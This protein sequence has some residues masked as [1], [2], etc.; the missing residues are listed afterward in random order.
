MSD[1]D[2]REFLKKSL[3]ASTGAAMAFSLEEQVLVAHAD[4]NAKPKPA[5]KPA[6]DFPKGKIGDVE[7]SRII[8]GGNLISGYAHSRDLVY[9]STL[10][11]HYFTDEKIFETLQLCE[12]QG[13]NAAMLKMDADTIRIVNTY[14]RERGGA[15][16]WIAQITNP[17]EMIPDA[18]KA[19]DMGA[20]GVFTT[21]QMGDELVRSNKVD[22]IAKTVEYVK[23]NGAIAGVSCHEI[24]VVEACEKGGVNADFY[25]KTFHHKHYWS[26]GIETRNDNLFEETP[27]KTIEVMKTVTKPW[28]AFKVLAAGAIPVQEGFEFAVKNGADFLCVGMFDFQVEE[29]ALVGKKVFAEFKERSRPWRG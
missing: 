16:Q 18:K 19:I 22:R 15:I 27:E 21:G 29:D 17:D 3:V 7:I 11:K 1:V 8:C 23:S 10:L 13:I 4:D 24:A 6:T 9:V 5:A 20:A 14:W 2:R 25:M 12:Q 26:A 28:V